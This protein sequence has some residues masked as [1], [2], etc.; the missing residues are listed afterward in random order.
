MKKYEKTK[1]HNKDFFKSFKFATSGIFYTLST[2]RNLKIQ[3][4]FAIIAIVLG[5]L[6]KISLVEWGML[7]FAIMFVLFAEMINTAIESTV[8]LFTEEFNEKAKIAKDVAAGAVLIASLNS[9]IIGA[10]IFLEK[11]LKYIII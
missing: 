10:L 2:Q 7:V 1:W 11:I 5:L 9:I 3:T 4:I 8:D 6:L